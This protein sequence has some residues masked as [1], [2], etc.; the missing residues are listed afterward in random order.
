MPPGFAARPV[1]LRGHHLLCLLTY[2]GK[3]YG[4]GFVANLDRI[5]ERIAR[6]APVVLVQGPDDV[7]APLAGD[8]QAHCHRAGI[9]ARDR[10][11][12]RDVAAVLGRPLPPGA[13]L[14]FVARLGTMRRAFAAGR[15]RI[16]CAGCPWHGLCTSVARSDF[17]A[18]RVA[19][20]GGAR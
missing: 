5:A 10:R 9:A 20:Q 12:A 4:P 18:A 8:P 2:V 3:G 1:R 11:A 17:T 6:G 16:A 15:T 14:A 13:R 19:P 7:C